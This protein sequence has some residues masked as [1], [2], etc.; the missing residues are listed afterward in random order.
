MA[1]NSSNIIMH[2]NIYYISLPLLYVYSLKDSFIDLI[3]GDNFISLSKCVPK[4]QNLHRKC[5]ECF[6]CIPLRETLICNILTSKTNKSA[7]NKNSTVFCSNFSPLF[8]V[9][10]R[11]FTSETWEFEEAS[12]GREW[13]W[14]CFSVYQGITYIQGHEGTA[15]SLSILV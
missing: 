1:R 6:Y 11:K 14:N 7:E 13:N 15:F 2:F 10:M 9:Q 3:L 4:I 12:S 5:F 8:P